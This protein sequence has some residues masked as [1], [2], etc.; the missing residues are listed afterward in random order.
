MSPIE[1]LTLEPVKLK[2]GF[3]SVNCGTPVPFFIHL[4]C[5]SL[6]YRVSIFW[7]VFEFVTLKG[8]F[9]TTFFDRYFSCRIR[10]DVVV[11]CQLSSF[12]KNYVGYARTIK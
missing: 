4:T 3:S 6:L 2:I 11:G 7:H 5:R 10:S 12:D 8:P 9:L 1:Y